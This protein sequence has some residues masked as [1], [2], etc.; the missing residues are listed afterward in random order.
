[1]FMEINYETLH[2]TNNIC[3]RMLKTRRENPMKK[4]Y[5]PFDDK[6]LHFHVKKIVFL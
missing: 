6:K 2:I 5:I 1:M 4:I 3:M